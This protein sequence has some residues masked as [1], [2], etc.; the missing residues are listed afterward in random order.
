MSY[1]QI[2]KISISIKVGGALYLFFFSTK[3]QESELVSKYLLQLKN[4][5]DQ[6][7]VIGKVVYDGVIV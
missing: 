4:L 5:N 3:L 7:Y 1:G 6:L 2:S